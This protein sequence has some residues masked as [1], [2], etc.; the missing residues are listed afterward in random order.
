MKKALKIVG[1]TLLALVGLVVLLVLTLP[2]WLGPVVKPAANAS[3]SQ[4]TGATFNLGE[5]SLN[6]YTGTLHVG[7]MQLSNPTNGGFKVEE[8]CL[9]LGAF[10]VDVDMG[11]V[12]SKKVVISSV[13]LD[14]LTIRSTI[15]GGNFKQIGANA[16]GG[17][18]ADTAE[19]P[20]AQ[21][22]EQPVEQQP[23][24][25]AAKGEGTKVQID[26][27]VLK[28]ITV[29][30]GIVPVPIPTLTIE[31]IG[32]D[33]PEGASLT[34]VF[35]TVWAKILSAAG[36]VSGKL[37]DLGAGAANAVGNAATGAANAVGDAAAGAANAV[38]GAVGTAAGAIGDH[39]GKAADAIG[40]GAGKAV[41]AVKGLFN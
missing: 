35:A 13:V 39:A 38:G 21:P 36:A 2:L 18:A 19:Q 24:R 37:G 41:N 9:E 5:L 15:T 27:L 40:Q 22:A 7:D 25:P 32:A 20:V 34:D 10:D 6:P 14:G 26:K 29:K 3:V 11:T 28:N 4:L 30:V 17:K 1:I 23:A 12:L 16:S 31:G 8:K 33:K